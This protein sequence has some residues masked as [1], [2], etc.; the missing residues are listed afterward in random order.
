MLFHKMNSQNESSFSEK[1]LNSAAKEQSR[2]AKIVIT[3]GLRPFEDK[4][5]NL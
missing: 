1:V 4:F 3:S 5:I 2:E